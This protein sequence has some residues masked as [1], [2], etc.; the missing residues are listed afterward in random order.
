MA[1]IVSSKNVAIFDKLVKKWK[2][3]FGKKD[4]KARKAAG[5]ALAKHLSQQLPVSADSTEFGSG[6]DY[7]TVYLNWKSKKN[8]NQ[9]NQSS[10]K[11][12]GYKI[13]KELAGRY[14][15]GFDFVDV[16]DVNEIKILLTDDLELN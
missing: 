15:N 1:K 7:D 16:Q 5:L 2:E 10:S 13:I 11:G 14:N 6:E 3:A 4:D 8:A 9:F 12:I